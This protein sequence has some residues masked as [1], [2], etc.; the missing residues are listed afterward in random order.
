MLVGFTVSA[1]DSDTFDA[2]LDN[3][4]FRRS[5]VIFSD[6]FESGNTSDWS[7]TTP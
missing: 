4:E 7:G 5:V 3:L 1:P 2:Y 6:G